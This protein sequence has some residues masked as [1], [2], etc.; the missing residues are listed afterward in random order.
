MMFT[1]TDPRDSLATVTDK[2]KKAHAAVITHQTTA[3]E[4]I[5]SAC[6]THLCDLEELMGVW[7]AAHG[8]GIEVVV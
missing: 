6:V 2:F 7:C 3:A 1:D 4:F 5:G 8:V